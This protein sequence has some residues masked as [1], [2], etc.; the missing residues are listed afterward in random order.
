MCIDC[1]I[2]DENVSRACIEI[3]S[4]WILFFHLICYYCD[5]VLVGWN[6]FG[7]DSGREFVG[8]MHSVNCICVWCSHI[9]LV[10]LWCFCYYS[11]MHEWLARVSNKTEFL[12]YSTHQAN[13]MDCQSKLSTNFCIYSIKKDKNTPNLFWIQAWI[14]HKIVTYSDFT[15]DFGAFTPFSLKH[16]LAIFGVRK[17]FYFLNGNDTTTN[18]PG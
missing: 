17:I 6:I 15:C 18:A 5:Y 9:L 10:L 16:S 11:N 1:T 3:L 14:V 8:C 12:P 13:P 2:I 4:H 7:C